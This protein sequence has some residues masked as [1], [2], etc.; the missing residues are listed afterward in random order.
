M[1]ALV[2]L[3]F[4]AGLAAV[5]QSTAPIPN[6]G[7][8]SLSAIASGPKMQVQLR[9][10]LEVV[11]ERVLRLLGRWRHGMRERHQL[12][13]LDGYTLRD[14]GIGQ[15]ERLFAIAFPHRVGAAVSDE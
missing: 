1:K 13:N 3:S 5:R 11:V 7:Y 8:R 9:T 15:T 4:L 10:G 6:A 14:I 12:Q 2:F